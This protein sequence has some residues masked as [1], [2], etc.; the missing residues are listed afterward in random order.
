MPSPTAVAGQINMVSR[1]KAAWRPFLGTAAGG[2][3]RGL[4]IIFMASVSAP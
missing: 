4:R 1:V 2:A 3:Q